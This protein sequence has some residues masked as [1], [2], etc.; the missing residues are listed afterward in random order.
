MSICVNS[1]GDDV[2]VFMTV[3]AVEVDVLKCQFWGIFA[4][5]GF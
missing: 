2:Q 3:A 5:V 4:L 1:A